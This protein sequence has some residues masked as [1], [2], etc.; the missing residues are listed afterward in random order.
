M[1]FF[2]PLQRLLIGFKG[3]FLVFSL[4]DLGVAE[5]LQR[6]WCRYLGQFLIIDG[7]V[8]AVTN[9]KLLVEK[10]TQQGSGLTSPAQ[11]QAEISRRLANR[12]TR[13]RRLLH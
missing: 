9:F 11:R 13:L 3:F 6:S 7:S 12:A 5:D 1:L 8:D 4:N 2:K 10:K